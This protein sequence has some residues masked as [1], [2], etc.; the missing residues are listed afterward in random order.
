ML[1][2]HVLDDIFIQF[3]ACN[4]NPAADDDAAKREQRHFGRAAADVDDHASARFLNRQSS[5]DRSSY[6]LFDEIHLARACADRGV[7]NSAFFDFGY[8]AGDANHHA[9]TGNGNP[10]L[11]V[12]LADEV[13][14]HRLGNFKLTDNTVA[15]R[16]DDENISRVLAPHFFGS[17]PNFDW[18]A[19]FL[20]DSDERRLIDYNSLA[21]YAHKGIGC[22]KVDADIKRE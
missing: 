6:R 11:L 10:R 19:R 14:E 22:A 9:R 4:A 2:T 20:L 21:S 16:P 8:A 12:R 18:S 7:V 17:R 15:Q 1:G 3:I 13:I 5:A